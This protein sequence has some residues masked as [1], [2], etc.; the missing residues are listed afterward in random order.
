MLLALLSPE[1]REIDWGFADSQLAD[2]S[3]SNENK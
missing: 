3:T 1:R 2:A